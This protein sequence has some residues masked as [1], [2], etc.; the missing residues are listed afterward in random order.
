MT[1]I[2]S[3]TGNNFA[4]L[5]A[6]RGIT[7]DVI[8]P[9]MS[10]I[11]QQKTWLIGVAG[12][13]RACD[14]LQYGIKYPTPPKSIGNDW[15]RWMVTKIIPL[16]DGGISTVRDEDWE[17][18][19]VTHGRSFLITNSLGL[20]TAEPYWSIGSGS[21]L[22]LGVL[23]DKQYDASWYKNHDIIA[24]HALSVASMH[25]PFTRGTIDVWVSYHTGHIHQ[26]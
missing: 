20:L 7:S 1:T 13:A 21:K 17:A 2:V 14:I 8:H 9:D 23:A 4:T 10:K 3:T 11:I 18:I 16:I 26:A 22:A 6:D 24:K 25:D 19:F 5:A 15:Y 12:D